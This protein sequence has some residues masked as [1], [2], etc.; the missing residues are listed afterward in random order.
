[1]MAGWNGDTAVAC[2]QKRPGSF[3]D[4][5]YLRRT[6]VSTKLVLFWISGARHSTGTASC[7]PSLKFDPELGRASFPAH[8]MSKKPEG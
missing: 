7:Q 3:R 8:T 1:M 2:R 6:K 5:I 4:V